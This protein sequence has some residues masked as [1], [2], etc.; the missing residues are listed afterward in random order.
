MPP[1]N[2]QRIIVCP[3]R[4]FDAVN[5]IERATPYL[6]QLPAPR[7]R[8]RS[9]RAAAAA[10]RLRRMTKTASAGDALASTL[11]PSPT[12]AKSDGISLANGCGKFGARAHDGTSARCHAEDLARPLLPTSEIRP[13]MWRT[14]HSLN[15]PSNSAQPPF[16]REQ[17]G[18]RTTRD[19]GYWQQSI[20]SYTTQTEPPFWLMAD[21]RLFIPWRQSPR[22]SQMT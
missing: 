22:R 21:R 13:L 10:V 19:Q 12:P 1:Y 20:P 11:H 7:A 17:N 14:E 5:S 3:C 16:A 2:A 18:R 15:S 6:V 9:C 8:S 4:M